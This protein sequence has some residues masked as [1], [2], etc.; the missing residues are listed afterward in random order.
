MKY[1]KLFLLIIIILLIFILTGCSEINEEHE[2]E[3]PYLKYIVTIYN[4]GRVIDKIEVYSNTEYYFGVNSLKIF[5]D[6]SQ[7]PSFYSTLDYT[8]ETIKQ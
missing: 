7:T 4:G 1:K 6:S 8:V 3:E 5:E 2:I